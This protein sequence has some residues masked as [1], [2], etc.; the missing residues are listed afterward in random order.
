MHETIIHLLA[1]VIAFLISYYWWPTSTRDFMKVTVTGFVLGAS[2][3]FLIILI[4][5]IPVHQ[6]VVVTHTVVTKYVKP[7]TIV[8]RDKIITVIPGHEYDPQDSKAICHGSKPLMIDH[9]DI[10]DPKTDSRQ[11]WI[12]GHVPGSKVEIT[13]AES[14]DFGDFWHPGDTLEVVQGSAW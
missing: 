6:N 9:V 7:P 1:F 2:I 3:G 4:R 12:Y 11:T 8:Y 13:C 5:L 10:T 14:G